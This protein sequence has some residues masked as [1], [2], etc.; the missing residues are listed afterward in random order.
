MDNYNGGSSFD[1]YQILTI[2]LPVVSSVV[3]WFVARKKRK[4]DFLADLQTS[5]DLLS[6]KYNN[7]LRELVEVKEQNSKLL[8]SQNEMKQQIALLTQENLTLKRTVD[9]LNERL[10][11]VKTIT[12][13]K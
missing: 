3:T 5:I 8:V 4:N 7:A 11:N 12:R 10:S 6:E 2:I 1:I 9:E 13:T